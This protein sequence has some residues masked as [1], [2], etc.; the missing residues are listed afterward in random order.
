MKALTARLTAEPA[1]YIV[2]TLGALAALI[3]AFAPMNAASAAIL[4]GGLTALG[5]V[6]VAIL[7]RPV[8][9]AAISGAAAVLVQSLVLLGVHWTAGQQGAVVAMINAAV[10]LVA[11]R[12]NLTPVASLRARA[13][14]GAA[15]TAPGEFKPPGAL[16][17][18]GRL[19][20]SYV[21][22]VAI[23]FGWQPKERNDEKDRPHP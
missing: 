9:V 3:V 16:R 8:D 14:A 21:Y 15:M 4:S 18:I 7:A 1:A 20:A 13:S 23:S 6:I 19:I 12:P 2:T 17:R 11:M 22:A 5:T 10:A